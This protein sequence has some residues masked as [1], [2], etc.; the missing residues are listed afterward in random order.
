LA[1][2][3]ASSRQPL[4]SN[5][6]VRYASTQPTVP[7]QTVPSPGADLP[8][9]FS[10]QVDLNHLD[11]LN[12]PEQI[13]FM[14]ALGLDYGW[15]PTSMMQWCLE[16]IYVYTGVPWWAAI[17]LTALAVRIAIFKPSLEASKQSQV[18]QDLRKHPRYQKAMEQM[19]LSMMDKSGDPMASLA[20]KQEIQ[21]IHKAAGFKFWKT[22][23]PMVNIP[24][25]YGM[26]RLLKGMGELPIP[27]MLS[28]GLLW[29]PDLTVPDP[30]FI[31][32]VAASAVMFM[33]LRVCFQH[34]LL[35]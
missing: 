31:L 26:F 28:G 23:I 6:Q 17:G 27:T 21:Q 9:G 16:H 10:S 24:L 32:P 3:S 20:A 13:G 4:F 8:T 34:L 35:E 19:K 22:L 14:K 25:G 11:L 5:R 2:L 7:P 12:I 33:A 1:A 30:F 18:V 29:F 15:G